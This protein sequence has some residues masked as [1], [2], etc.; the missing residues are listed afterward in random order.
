MQCFIS[1]T[2]KYFQLLAQE[3][4]DSDFDIEVKLSEGLVC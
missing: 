4:L 3:G 1:L 2:A